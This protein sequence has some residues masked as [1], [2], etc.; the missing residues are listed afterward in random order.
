MKIGI[1]GPISTE[2]VAT[3]LGDATPSLK[4]AGGAPLLG[5]LIRILLERGHSV[6]AYTM[7]SSLR[8][9]ELV[10]RVAS[11]GR[12]RIYYVPV[13]RRAFRYED[14]H[15]GRMSDFFRLERKWLVRVMR[16]DEPDIV[17]AHWTYEFA[18]AAI[19]SGLPYLVTAHDSPWH[20][21]RYTPSIYR[22]CRYLLAKAVVSR[23]ANMTAVSPFVAGELARWRRKPI[24][25]I[26]NPVPQELERSGLSPRE[27]VG[28]GGVSVRVMM[29]L[30]GWVRYKNPEPAL[31]AFALIRKEFP[32]ISLHVYGWGYGPG[33]SAQQW[34]TARGCAE[35]VVFHG[36]VAYD[37]ILAAMRSADMLLHPA[38]LESCCMTI[39]EAMRVGL[40][41]IGGRSSGGVPWQL[42]GGKAG[43]LV[44]VTSPEAIAKAIR[45]L[46][47]D[48]SLYSEL[49]R[50]ALIRAEEIFASGAVVE[51]YESVYQRVLRDVKGSVSNRLGTSPMPRQ[52][53]P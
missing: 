16:D 45:T 53:K 47:C 46:V 52:G 25:V 43:I 30:N 21:A 12:F 35:G 28:G 2:S 5:T 29:V 49:S 42:D 8:I 31:K 9:D 51:A 6:S 24:S 7:D 41:V 13:R 10:P 22:I 20:V 36:A 1:A 39:V 33:E 37:R 26:A 50:S 3:L 27:G 15:F 11:A 44:D 17:H 32:D 4:G 14:G 48:A 23:A 18:L 19:R 40:P 38:L 34:T